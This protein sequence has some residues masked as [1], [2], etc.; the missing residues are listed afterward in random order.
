MNGINY[1]KLFNLSSISRTRN[2]FYARLILLVFICI[3]FFLNESH[4]QKSYCLTDIKIREK[5]TIATLTWKH[6]ESSLY[7]V[8]RST[9][10]PQQ[11]FNQI[12]TTGSTYSLFN[13]TMVKINTL[14]YY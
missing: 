10:G 4:A 3:T 2:P 12:G 8:F 11:G 9:T 5:A 13:D 6:N 14:Y 7:T 1:C